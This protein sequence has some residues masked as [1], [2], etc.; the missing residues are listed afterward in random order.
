MQLAARLLESGFY[1]Q[2][3]RP[4]TVPPGT[5][6]LRVT[7]MATHT[8]E[9]MDQALEA[10]ERAGSMGV[11]RCRER[12]RVSN[13]ALGEGGTRSRSIKVS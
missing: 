2:G 1:V 10:F 8:A 9:Q 4:P 6:R 3:I 11:N 5:S 13:L 7:T 12:G